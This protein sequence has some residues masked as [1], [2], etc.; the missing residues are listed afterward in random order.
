[1]STNQGLMFKLPTYLI[2]DHG[3]PGCRLVHRCLKFPWSNVF[4]CLILDTEA[5]DN[6]TK[7]GVPFWPPDSGNISGFDNKRNRNQSLARVQKR[8][9]GFAVVTPD[10]AFTRHSRYNVFQMPLNRGW[11]MFRGGHVETERRNVIVTSW[12][13][14]QDFSG[15]ARRRHRGNAASCTVMHQDS[16]TACWE[17]WPFCSAFVTWC[18]TRLNLSM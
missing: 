18:F 2:Q 12:N 3:H 1:M 15:P 8:V 9:S 4:V 14:H 16:R 6:L 10:L 17:R 5:G 13:Q 11:N 7:L